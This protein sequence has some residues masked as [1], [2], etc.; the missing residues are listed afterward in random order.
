MPKRKDP[1]TKTSHIRGEI[2]SIPITILDIYKELTIS[3]DIMFVSGICFID[4]ISR[5][6]KFMTAEHI[7]NADATT[8][9]EYIIQVKQVCMPWGFKITNI[10]MDG[11]FSCIRGNLAELQIN[12]NVFSNNKHVGDM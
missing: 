12:I 7:A 5:H 11:Q 4:T 6:L 2:L 3:G 8:L 9:Q 1:K 10:L